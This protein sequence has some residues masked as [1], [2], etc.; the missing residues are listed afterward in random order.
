MPTWW[1]KKSSK[2]KEHEEPRG[3][4]STSNGSSGGGGGVL[5][6]NFSNKSPIRNSNKN[7]YKP[8]NPRSF[9]DASSNFRNT[10]RSSRDFSPSIN[11]A[12][13]GSS[14]CWDSDAGYKIG[15]P[16]PRP[17]VS[18]T[19]SLSNDQGITFGFGSASVSGSSVSSN[20]SYDDPSTSNSQINT[21][22][23]VQ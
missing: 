21:A 13:G 9:D 19:Q 22:R 2:P 7:G 1:G 23:L 20:G 8:E 4:S 10:P 6:F 11:S 17:S 18:S 16:L 15:V 3:G 5:H 14:S 12:G